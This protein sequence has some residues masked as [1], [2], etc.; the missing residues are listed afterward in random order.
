MFAGALHRPYLIPLLVFV[1]GI[2]VSINMYSLMVEL[3]QSDRKEAFL[4]QANNHFFA[5]EERM[6]STQDILSAL[7]GFIENT[8]HLKRGQF[9]NFS[10]NLL[11]RHPEVQAL[12]WI[13]RVANNKRHSY[14]IRAQAEG[15]EGFSIKERIVNDGKSL[16]VPVIGRPEYY[17]VFFAYP[18]KGNEA[19]IGFDLGSNPERLDA[20]EIA[21]DTGQFVMSQGI[22]LVQETGS[23]S[24]TLMFLPMYQPKE[25]VGNEVINNVPDTVLKRRELLTG[26]VLIVL[27]IGDLI[28]IPRSNLDGHLDIMVTD[29]V[30]SEILYDSRTDSKAEA[31]FSLHQTRPFGQRKWLFSL[32]PKPGAYTNDQ[33][34]IDF[35][36]LLGAI[37]LSCLS[38]S[39]TYFLMRS[40]Q[41][42]ETKT[43]DLQK[44]EQRF[45]LAAAGTSVGIWDWARIDEDT[46]F[47]SSQFYNLLGYESGE[48]IASQKQFDTFIH[49]GDIERTHQMMDA[50][51]KDEGDF[52]IEYRLRTKSGDYKWF[53]CSGRAGSD[54]NG[55]H[56]RFV[57]S[58]QDIHRQKTAEVAI[59]A[60][61]EELKRSNADLE[62]FAYVASHDL[63][64]PLSG[65]HKL[66]ELIE[67]NIQNQ[68]FEETENYLALMKGRIIR[69]Q[70]L[71]ASLLEYSRVGQ[72][73]ED[74][75]SIDLNVMVG[76][77]T[78][79]LAVQ[80]H[81][82]E[83]LYDLPTI[84]AHSTVLNQ[85]FH[86]LISNAIKHHDQDKGLIKIE[87]NFEGEK[88]VF[89]ITDDGPG[90]PNEM[91]DKVFKM[92]QTLRPRD[93]VEGSGMGLAI[94]KKL[95]V[96]HG[97][98]IWIDNTDHNVGTTMKFSIPAKMSA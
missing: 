5:V 93:E 18:L 86:N 29:I 85:T 19:A 65:V 63:R 34:I 22:T 17:P 75:K 47:W 82:F 55:N 84:K 69:L 28:E 94:V 41:A 7:K 48:I 96:Y 30:S 54:E 77:V 53:R 87:H 43:Q 91:Q 83:V 32:Y 6:L 2:V 33:Q 58:I 15:Y 36:F 3:H 72:S 61:A 42:V 97:G 35:L 60:Y 45:S 13:P 44:S 40:Y 8:E 59:Q 79:L 20:L 21:R 27:R 56:T 76:D 88:H 80:D 70:N 11:K 90:I 92:F 73:R 10:N 95:V 31:D 26:F 50:H 16:L 23:Q 52:D 25:Y 24:G 14:E 57:G 4:H 38:G 71:L 37:F 46:Q 49:P 66:A 1:I 68:K 12:E 89:A 98:N 67:L 78:D 74:L 62:Q 51:L 9:D 81:G 64:A 39:Y